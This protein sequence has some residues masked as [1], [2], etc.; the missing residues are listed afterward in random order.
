[1]LSIIVAHDKN[2]VI[3][4]DNDLPWSRLPKDMKYFRKTTKGHNIIMGRK[5]YESIGKPLKKRTNI[6]L[7]RST[8][9][10][11]KG[12]FAFNDIDTIRLFVNNHPDEEHFVI[13][14]DSI[15]KQF[16]PHSDKL[17]I[18]KICEEY[19]GDRHFPAYK[20]NDNHL[21][22]EDDYGSWVLESSNTDIDVEDINLEFLV[23][24][25]KR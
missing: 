14:G 25:R 7:T 9:F 3:G 20:L 8:D 15:Y 6:V 5:T 10:K 19:V 13:G 24:K 4:R 12:C 21:T 2:F 1:M 16:L 11:P 17:Y 22:F 18:T 23:F